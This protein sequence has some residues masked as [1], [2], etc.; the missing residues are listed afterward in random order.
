MQADELLPGVRRRARARSR[1]RTRTR[2]DRARLQRR[3][4]GLPAA[5]ARAG[6]ECCARAAAASSTR[7][8]ATAAAAARRCRGT[9]R[10]WSWCWATATRVPVVAEMMIGRAP[11]VDAGARRPD[12]LARA[13]ADLGQRRRTAAI[14]D[15]GS[16]HGTWLDGARVT[17]P[18]AAARRR[19]DPARRPELR[20]ERRRDDAEAGRTIVVRPGASAGRAGDGPAGVTSHGDAVRDAA[21][22]ALGL[23][24]QAARRRRGPRAAGCCKDL[25]TDT[26]PAAVATTTRSCFEL[27]D[28][29]RSLVELIGVAEQR[30][31]PDRAGAA[32]AAARRP[33]RA[34]VPRRAWRARDA[35]RPRRP[36]GLLAQAVQAAR[37]GL[38]RRRRR[39]SSA[40]YRR[41]GWVLF[42]RPALSRSRRWSW[43]GSARSST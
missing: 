18:L 41:G 12:G 7:G 8:R 28:G 31:G 22:G 34:R 16:S 1:S 24:A 23:R 25:D 20:V 21:A 19:E 42:T 29:T 35:A 5:D 4:P 36:R 32:R 30:F 17:G 14:E 38:H 3:Q 39:S 2:P 37:E 13:R 9:S 11:G 33:R 43:P 27:L 6:S 15:A 40:L 26:L 10:R